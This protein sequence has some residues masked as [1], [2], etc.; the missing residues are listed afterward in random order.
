MNEVVGWIGSLL[1]AVCALPQVIHTFKTRKTDD[2]NELFLWLWFLG[3]IFTFSYVVV[4]DIASK[5]YHIPL[6]FNYAFNLLML[7]YLIY[8]KYSYNSKPT[9]L[10]LIRKKIRL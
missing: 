9:S 5:N 2:V 7:F 4:D 8:A 3:E 10:S 6:Y 1:F